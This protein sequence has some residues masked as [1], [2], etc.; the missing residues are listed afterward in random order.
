MD[1]S[2][3]VDILFSGSIK[4]VILTVIRAKVQ[5][6]VDYANIKSELNQAI[7]LYLKVQSPDQREQLEAIIEESKKGLVNNSNF[8]HQK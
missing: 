8:P 2:M 5:E 4:D 1:T 3:L 6:G 7:E